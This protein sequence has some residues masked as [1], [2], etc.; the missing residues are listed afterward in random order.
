MKTIL[1]D[2]RGLQEA[3]PEVEPE[4][5]L[6]GAGWH[7][8]GAARSLAVA[9]ACQLLECSSTASLDCIYAIL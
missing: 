9:P 6:G 5:P 1:E 3:T 8:L 2:Y 4:R 7:H